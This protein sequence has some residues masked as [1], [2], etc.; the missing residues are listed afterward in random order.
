MGSDPDGLEAKTRKDLPAVAAVTALQ[1]C[2][3]IRRSRTGDRRCL[4]LRK[5]PDGLEP[6]VYSGPGTAY[7]LVGLDTSWET[8]F[9]SASNSRS[10]YNPV[11]CYCLRWARAI[12]TVRTKGIKRQVVF[13][14]SKFTTGRICLVLL[15]RPRMLRRTQSLR[16]EP[17]WCAK[18]H[19]NPLGPRIAEFAERRA[20]ILAAMLTGH[21]EKGS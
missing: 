12:Q 6:G 14:Q 2:Q 21:S 20:C 11:S 1:I 3:F 7:G 5:S 8:C 16:A 4:R 13:I 15:Q 18:L 17:L 19:T 9:N 10:L